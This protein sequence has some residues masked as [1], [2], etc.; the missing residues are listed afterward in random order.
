MVV[1]RV[2]GSTS[3]EAIWRLVIPRPTRT[4][5]S[6]SR[7][8][9]VGGSS[10]EDCSDSG[11]EGVKGFSSERAYSMACSMNIARPSAHASSHDASSS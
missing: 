7:R 2:L 11:D 10:E 9:R 8:V 3:S 5:T 4:A 1:H 6:F